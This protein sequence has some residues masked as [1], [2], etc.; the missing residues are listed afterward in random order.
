[1][2]VYVLCEIAVACAGQHQLMIKRKLKYKSK[3]NK[4]HAQAPSRRPQASLPVIVRNADPR[5]SNT[6]A[7]KWNWFRSG[8]GRPKAVHSQCTRRGPE[9]RKTWCT[10]EC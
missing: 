5:T 4:I 6:G 8:Y 7:D 3:T 1:M 9:R 2:C 10:A